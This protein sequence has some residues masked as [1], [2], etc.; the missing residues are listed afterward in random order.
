MFFFLFLH[1]NIC[2]GYS[3]GV[4][5]EDASNEYPQHMFLSRIKS[6]INPLIFIIPGKCM[7]QVLIRVPYGEIS[8]IILSFSQSYVKCTEVIEK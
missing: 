2:C 3:L 6:N 5:H 1:E 4:P 8:K 7:S